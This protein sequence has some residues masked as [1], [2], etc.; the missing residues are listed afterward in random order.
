MVRPWFEEL[1]R[2]D[3]AFAAPDG[4]WASFVRV[5][6]SGRIFAVPT[7]IGDAFAFLRAVRAHPQH[8]AV[9]PGE[10]HLKI[11]EDLC[12]R[13]DVS[14]DLVPDAYL[15][16]LALEQDAQLASLDRDFARFAGLRWVRPGD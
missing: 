12:Y 2:G 7:P 4:V 3:G 5:S 13:C 10:D 1:V 11:F 6:T 16:A 9:T 8:L 15:A 14:G